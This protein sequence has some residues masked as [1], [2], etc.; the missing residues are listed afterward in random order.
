MMISAPD[1]PF[2]AALIHFW[3]VFARRPLHLSRLQGAFAT[4]AALAVQED[5][6]RSWPLILNAGTDQEVPFTIEALLAR[7]RERH[8]TRPQVPT[9]TI[10]DL[11][12]RW[13]GSTIKEVI[14]DWSGAGFQLRFAK[15]VRLAPKKTR[16]DSMGSMGVACSWHL[17]Q[18]HT[19]V[20]SSDD[21]AA[22]INTCLDTLQ[23]K[24]LL[25]PELTED[26]YL[27]LSWQAGSWLGI[28][29][30][31]WVRDYFLDFGW[32]GEH[33]LAFD[34]FAGTFRAFE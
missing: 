15:K 28:Q 23:G 20:C 1:T 29:P 6:D 26:G 24:K 8:A 3:K 5:P 22:H 12:T 25:A 21:A 34:Y 32:E 13:T 17:V 7:E 10:Q 30:D 33:I 14:T 19:R 16:T 18:A 11:L 9:G 2:G 31:G 27:R 4:L